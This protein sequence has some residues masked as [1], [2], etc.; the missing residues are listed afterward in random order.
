MGVSVLS[1]GANEAGEYAG[2]NTSAVMYCNTSGW[3][4]GPV[5]ESREQAEE[6][7]AWLSERGFPDPRGL[8]SSE[9]GESY[10][11]F[12]TETETKESAGAQQP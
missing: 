1:G 12:K 9:L 10:R 6:F 7:M 2:G 8:R 4:F 3:A 5:F 11:K